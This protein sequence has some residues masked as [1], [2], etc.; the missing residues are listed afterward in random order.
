LFW[1]IVVVRLLGFAPDPTQITPQF[2]SQALLA[3]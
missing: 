3:G 1:L 2:S